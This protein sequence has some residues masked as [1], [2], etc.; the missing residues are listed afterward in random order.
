MKTSDKPKKLTRLEKHWKSK[1][2]RL[3]YDPRTETH[4]ERMM[5]KR[6]RQL[7]RRVNSPHIDT[8]RYTGAVLR[9]IRANS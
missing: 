9:K 5:R 2:A 6:K 7:S 8:S 3:G 1:V 4:K